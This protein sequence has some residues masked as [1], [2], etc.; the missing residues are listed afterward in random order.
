MYP[1]IPLH[2]FVYPRMKLVGSVSHLLIPIVH[3]VL[4]RRGS[5]KK[6]KS[7]IQL[8]VS[9]YQERENGNVL[10]N[11][12]HEPSKSVRSAATEQ[13]IGIRVRFALFISLA[14]GSRVEKWDVLDKSNN[15]S[16][17]CII[18]HAQIRGEHGHSRFQI[19]KSQIDIN[20]NLPLCFLFIIR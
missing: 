4:E 6:P 20:S 7:S 16:N 11:K 2:P 17:N 10:S 14:P 9:F 8:N 15:R 5:V 19:P 12:V 1:I 3:D 18:R 13:W